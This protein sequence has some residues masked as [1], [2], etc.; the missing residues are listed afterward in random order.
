L[1]PRPIGQLCLELLG[2]HPED[3]LA[4]LIGSRLAAAE[5]VGF[6]G[7]AVVALASE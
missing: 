2:R 3:D 1:P 4:T 7:A 5:L 6:D